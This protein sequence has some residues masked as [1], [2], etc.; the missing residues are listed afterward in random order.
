MCGAKV[1]RCMSQTDSGGA[2]LG[3]DLGLRVQGLRIKKKVPFM[4]LRDFLLERGFS[5]ASS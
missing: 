5:N 1:S 2:G 3:F 4:R